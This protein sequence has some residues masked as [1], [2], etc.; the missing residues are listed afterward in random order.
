MPGYDIGNQTT[1]FIKFAFFIYFNK[2]NRLCQKFGQFILI[3][4]TL[5]LENSIT[6]LV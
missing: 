5:A 3:K 1:I 4:N 2:N 6:G